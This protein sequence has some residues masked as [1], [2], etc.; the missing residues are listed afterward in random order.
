MVGAA[1]SSLGVP[2]LPGSCQRGLDGPFNSPVVFPIKIHHHLLLFFR[3]STPNPCDRG[4]K[5]PYGL[6]QKKALRPRS[7]CA[8]NKLDRDI[9]QSSAR[10][11][12]TSFLRVRD[13]SDVGA[14]P[15]QAQWC[16]PNSLKAL[17]LTGS[18]TRRFGPQKFE[19]CPDWGANQINHFRL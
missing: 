3:D 18:I 17:R 10:G 4:V 12:V 6:A 19:T 5:G 15:G 7:G 16:T 11:K 8:F 13:V 9:A 2:E 14:R 1:P